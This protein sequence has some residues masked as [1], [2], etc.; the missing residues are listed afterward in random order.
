MLPLIIE[1]TGSS[2]Q[3]KIF[4]KPQKDLG[5]NN[6]HLNLPSKEENTVYQYKQLRTLWISSWKECSSLGTQILP[7]T[8]FV[9]SL[10]IF[11]FLARSVGLSPHIF[12]ILFWGAF[13]FVEFQKQK[14]N[15]LPA[16]N[17]DIYNLSGCQF[18][19]TAEERFYRYKHIRFTHIFL[20][21]NHFKSSEKIHAHVCI[22]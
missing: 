16:E 3:I 5:K 2:Y 14:Q 1:N 10:L 21:C 12:P 9:A 19:F 20:A 15:M 4:H 17:G 11:S 18:I 13:L 22:I 7:P 6:V 8:V